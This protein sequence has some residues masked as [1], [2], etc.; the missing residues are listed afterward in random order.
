MLLEG[1]KHLDERGVITFNNDFDASQIKRIYTIENHSIEFIRGWQGHAIEQRWFA[2]M[3]GSFEISVIKV[4]DFDKP[5][6]DLLIEKYILKD[7]KLTYL[8]IPAGY[9]TA[10]KALELFS[11]LLVLADYGMGEISDEYRF[12]LDYF[13]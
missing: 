3:R 1:R 6:K 12:E 10:I 13:K 8:H 9:I 4:D 7:N 11:K 2:A 5:S